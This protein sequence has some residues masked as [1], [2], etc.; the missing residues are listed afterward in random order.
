MRMGEAGN[1]LDKR[2]QEEAAAFH[3]GL[4]DASQCWML[5][6]T[7]HRG[8][9]G[10]DLAEIASTFNRRLRNVLDR[11]MPEARVILWDQ[12]AEAETPGSCHHH[13][14][15]FIRVDGMT[16]AEV[17][18]LFKTLSGHVHLEPIYGDTLRSLEN[19]ARYS[20]R[21]TGA[22]MLREVRLDMLHTLESIRGE[23]GRGLRFT[24]GMSR[25]P[26]K[27]STGTPSVDDLM[28]DRVS[29]LRVRTYEVTPR[30]TVEAMRA[31][32]R[33]L[34]CE[35]ASMPPLINTS[36]GKPNAHQCQPHEI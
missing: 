32:Y 25:K 27:V 24:Y 3:G 19:I 11:Y 8:R 35:F 30:L 17:Q 23:S 10:D 26:T 18:K 7:V 9:M 29:S 5:T 2:A 34:Q 16:K 22:G 13:K 28:V 4:I 31:R 6:I 1:H 21:N 20:M 33:A 36:G 14:H 15:G 12:L